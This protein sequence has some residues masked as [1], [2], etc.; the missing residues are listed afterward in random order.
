MSRTTA[1]RS[2]ITEIG[3]SLN[4]LGRRNAGWTAPTGFP[5]FVA[6][7]DRRG[8]VP[9]VLV[10]SA[11]LS[12]GPPHPLIRRQCRGIRRPP[13][14]S[15]CNL[16]L[17]LN[18]MNIGQGLCNPFGAPRRPKLG[19]DSSRDSDA[20]H[21]S[22][23]HPWPIPKSR[24]WPPG[25]GRGH[26][27]SIG[28]RVSLAMDAS[29]VPVASTPVGLCAKLRRGLTAATGLAMLCIAAFARAQRLKC[30]VCVRAAGGHRLHL[31]IA[32]LHRCP[33]CAATASPSIEIPT[34][35]AYA[36]VMATLQH[37]NAG[38]Q[39]Q[40]L[41]YRYVS[42]VSWSGLPVG[43]HPPSWFS[44][45]LRGLGEQGLSNYLISHI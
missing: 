1:G 21:G 2:E 7:R 26:R 33:A 45:L 23:H 5:G 14:G 8:L 15:Q 4:T 40:H 25:L 13:P 17:A 29:L 36:L 16:P 3:G 18:V 37:R 43:S 42:G 20:P 12:N 11:R 35:A 38:Y 19:A 10:R 44:R 6:L 24:R 39:R 32:E 22:P 34:N 28:L 9:Q 31:P 41:R 30:C 27:P